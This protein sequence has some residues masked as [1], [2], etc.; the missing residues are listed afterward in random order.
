MS[1]ARPIHDVFKQLYA[2]ILKT[3]R[4][5]RLGFRIEQGILSHGKG[6]EYSLMLGVDDSGPKET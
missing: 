6:V 2:S 1:V 4:T 3:C 5:M